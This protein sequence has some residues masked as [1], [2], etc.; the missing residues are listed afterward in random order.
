[1]GQKPQTDAHPPKARET[2]PSREPQGEHK[3]TACGAVFEWERD[4]RKHELE[5]HASG[6]S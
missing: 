5:R 6:S 2:V 4:L 3:C 1:M